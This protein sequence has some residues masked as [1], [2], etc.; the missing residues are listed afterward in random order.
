M[1][2][3]GTAH[4]TVVIGFRFFVDEPDP[5]ETELALLDGDT[6]RL[7]EQ[8]VAFLHAHDHAVHAAEHGV[9]P[10]EVHELL[11]RALALGD[12][13]FELSRVRGEARIR[14]A[15]LFALLGELV[16]HQAQ[17]AHAI[18]AGDLAGIGLRHFAE[19]MIDRCEHVCRLAGFAQ[20]T[21]HAG[22]R[23]RARWHR[24]RRI[25]R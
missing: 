2:G 9:H 14:G 13:F 15:E 20:N 21:G 23:A 24:L 10:I 1:I 4:A 11:G 25:R 22:R 12:L 7:L 17:V 3:S 18:A 6:A 19:C 5:R 8:A 16:G